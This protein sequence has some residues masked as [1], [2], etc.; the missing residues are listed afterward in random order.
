MVSSASA[1]IETTAGANIKTAEG[2]PDYGRTGA[3]LI[4]VVA[5]WIILCCLVGREAHGSHFEKGKAAFEKGAGNDEIEER[6]SI[7]SPLVYFAN[8]KV[9]SLSASIRSSSRRCC[10]F[11]PPTRFGEGIQR[12]GVAPRARLDVRRRHEVV[13]PGIVPLLSFPAD[14]LLG[15]LY[16]LHLHCNL[17]I[18]SSRGQ[19]AFLQRHF[20]HFCYPCVVQRK[21]GCEALRSRVLLQRERGRARTQTWR[22]AK[23]HLIFDP[24]LVGS[25]D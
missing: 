1:Q 17:S 7:R 10:H 8:T 18:S 13:D 15:T 20:L 3:I 2:R 6:E 14:V 12:G 11:G 22:F 19:S 25:P 23:V 24:V 4:G 5:A 16:I 9:D 21:D